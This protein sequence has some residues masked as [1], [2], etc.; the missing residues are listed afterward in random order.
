MPK[1]GNV[2]IEFRSAEGQYQNLP[3]ILSELV[4]RK[5]A[6]LVV[7]GAVTGA[8]AATKSAA[9]AV[10]IVFVIGSDPVRWGLVASF[11]R[12]GG[13]ITGVTISVSEMIPKRVELLHE[14]VPNAAIGLITNPNNPNAELEV[15]K[16]AEMAIS[17][18]W[19]LKVVNVTREEELEDAFKEIANSGVG[20]VAFGSDALLANWRQQ[21]ASLAFRYTLPA[22]LSGRQFALAGGLMAYGPRVDEVF[23]MAGAYTARILNGAKPA[24]IPVWAPTT[25]DLIVNLK[26]AKAIGITVPPSILA[27]ADEVIE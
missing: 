22:I 11:A 14:L 3:S 1:V 13:N 18:G 5:V 7:G 2:A 9:A 19:M 8:L 10:P 17:D 15:K 20:G 23:R 16:L 21:L 24:D 12:P 6:V 4:G 27:R 26:T 25:F